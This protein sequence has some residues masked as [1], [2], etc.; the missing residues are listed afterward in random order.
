MYTPETMDY[1][2][3]V[4]SIGSGVHHK[5]GRSVGFS[6]LFFCGREDSYFSSNEKI[7]A[8]NT[9][10]NLVERRPPKIGLFPLLIT[11]C[12]HSYLW[13]VVLRSN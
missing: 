5:K 13:T 11:L 9:H 10:M 8:E 4:I 1:R 6:S 3:E 12:V 2:P 7:V